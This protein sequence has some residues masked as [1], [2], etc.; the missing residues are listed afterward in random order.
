M[1]V[2][3]SAFGSA[4]GLAVAMAAV[5]VTGQTAEKT[6]GLERTGIA[7][8]IR[9]AA[10]AP[11]LMVAEATI[12][13][14]ADARVIALPT[15]R[16]KKGEPALVKHGYQGPDGRDHLIEITIRVTPDGKEA[17]YTAT[18]RRGQAPSDID[19]TQTVTFHLSD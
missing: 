17:S 8:H 4:L 16:F 15:V 12:T 18:T 6:S 10:D 11:G 3:R 19:Q 7:L 14:L 9:P 13:D 2:S 1:R 5:V